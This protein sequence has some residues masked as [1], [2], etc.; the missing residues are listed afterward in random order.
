MVS[1][2]RAPAATAPQFVGTPVRT[3]QTRSSAASSRPISA[4]MTACGP[5]LHRAVLPVGLVRSG[6][7]WFREFAAHL[8]GPACHRAFRGSAPRRAIVRRIF[9]ERQRIRAGWPSNA[10]RV[11][12]DWRYGG[13]ALERLGRLVAIAQPPAASSAAQLPSA[14]QGCRRRG[15]YP[16]CPGLRILVLDVIAPRD[17]VAPFG[18]RL[19]LGIDPVE[20]QRALR[21]VIGDARGSGLHAGGHG[22]VVDRAG[23]DALAR[24]RLADE[25]ACRARGGFQPARLAQPDIAS[26]CGSA[27]SAPASLDPRQFD[28]R[29]FGC[30]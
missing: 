18:A 8:F 24:P 19:R 3:S 1:P 11:G 20:Q 21:I 28:P 15:T 12:R 26:A 5:H 14:T 29:A 13:A 4:S 2:V 27:H 17:A 22:P 16:P 7:A 23:T 10:Q 9:R 6:W 30:R 25:I